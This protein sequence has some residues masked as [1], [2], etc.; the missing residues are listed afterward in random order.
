MNDVDVFAWGWQ[1]GETHAAYLAARHPD[2]GRR[3]YQRLLT[4]V[5]PATAW[6]RG[7]RAGTIDTLYAKLMA[8]LGEETPVTFTID[9]GPVANV[10]RADVLCTYC[11][12]PVGYDVEL[13]ETP[14]GRWAHAA[15]HHRFHPEEP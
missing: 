8:P 13:V 15:C 9:R 14:S 10:R 2:E 4:A 12:R 7:H 5:L 6:G 1:V 11:G 3:F